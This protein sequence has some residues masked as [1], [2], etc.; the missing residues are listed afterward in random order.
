VLCSV[1]LLTGAP[2]FWQLSFAGGALGVALVAIG[3]LRT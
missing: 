3:M 2:I 1:T